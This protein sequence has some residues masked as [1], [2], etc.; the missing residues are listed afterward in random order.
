METGC[1]YCWSCVPIGCMDGAVCRHVLD[2]AL[3]RYAILMELCGDRLCILLELCT[4]RM[5]G[6]SCV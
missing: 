5:Y 1:V 4:D 2:E 6:W 3:Y